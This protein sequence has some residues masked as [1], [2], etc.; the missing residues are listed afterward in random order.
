MIQPAIIE[1]PTIEPVAED[2]HL[3]MAPEEPVDTGASAD[4]A[5]AAEPLPVVKG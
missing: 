2:P 1:E 3:A 5:Q 4:L